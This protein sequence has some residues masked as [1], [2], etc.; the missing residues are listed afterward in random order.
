MEGDPIE[1]HGLVGFVGWAPGR[2]WIGA[3]L[4]NGSAAFKLAADSRKLA[5]AAVVSYF[6]RTADRS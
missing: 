1:F 2:P 3:R 4:S 6:D 5:A